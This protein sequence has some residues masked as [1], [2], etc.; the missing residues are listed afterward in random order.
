MVEPLHAVYSKAC[1]QP[2]ADLLDQRGRRVI[3]FF[4]QVRVRYVEQQEI[5]AFDPQ[6]LSFFNINTAQDLER[7]QDL[8]RKAK[9]RSRGKRSS[10]P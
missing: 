5:E 10:G 4:H 9:P 1:A 8:A 6:H 3:G 2:I 7:M